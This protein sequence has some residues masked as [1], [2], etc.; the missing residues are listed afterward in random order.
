MF[1][2]PS[3]FAAL[4]VELT[5]EDRNSHTLIADYLVEHEPVYARLFKLQQEVRSLG[6]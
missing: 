5:A 4:T 3:S 6:L 1:G 2:L